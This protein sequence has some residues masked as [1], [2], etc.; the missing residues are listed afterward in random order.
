ME[1]MPSLNMPAQRLTVAI[2]LLDLPCSGPVTHSGEILTTGKS[3]CHDVSHKPWYFNACCRVIIYMD[4]EYI[5]ILCI[6]VL[7]CLFLC[8]VGVCVW[9]LAKYWMPIRTVSKAL[10]GFICNMETTVAVDKHKLCAHSLRPSSTQPQPS[11]PVQN[12]IC[13]SAHSCSS[14]DGHNDARNMLR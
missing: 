12:T 6:T 13:G 8:N 3:H 9:N 2:L 4:L 7:Y 10:P 11:L 1:E 5:L 14:D